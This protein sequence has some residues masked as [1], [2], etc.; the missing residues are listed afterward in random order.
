MTNLHA[1]ISQQQAARLLVKIHSEFGCEWNVQNQPVNFYQAPK[2]AVQAKV[3]AKPSLPA[4]DEAI[5][6]AIEAVKQAEDIATK[7]TDLE[8]LQAGLRGF[9]GCE[10]LSKTAQ[11]LVFSD[12]IADSKV[13]IIGESPEAEDDRAGKPLVGVSGQLLDKML[14]YVGLNRKE[15][16]YITNMVFWRPPGN[17][18]LLENEMNICA[19]FVKR[20]IELAAPKILLLVGNIPMQH[21]FKT[22]DSIAKNRGSW[23]EYELG[24]GKIPMLATF[25]PAY[26]LRDPMAKR[27]VW[28]DLCDFRAKLND[29][30]IGAG[31]GT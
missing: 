31:G 8:S 21:F 17:R 16:C 18:A 27:D 5:L 1:S 15:N 20:H 2:T 3:P 9:T 11:N 29:M 6:G 19:P 12:G 24:G 26:F 13:M 28:N 23:G 10:S 25:H 22:T 4:V 7:A 14:S 30:D